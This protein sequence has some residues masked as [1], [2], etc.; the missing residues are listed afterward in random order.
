VRDRLAAAGPGADAA[1]GDEDD[2]T[3]GGDTGEE[4]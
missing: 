3:D 2:F 1:E 4:A